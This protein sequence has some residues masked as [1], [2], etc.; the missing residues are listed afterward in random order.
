MST[1]TH[2]QRAAREKLVRRYLN[3]G[4]G[5]I[6]IAKK[7]NISKQAVSQFCEVRGWGDDVKANDARLR[8]PR[9]TAAGAA[10]DSD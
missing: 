3:E 6:W 1:F 2:Q 7:L 5:V 9:K 10:A 8:S 4:R